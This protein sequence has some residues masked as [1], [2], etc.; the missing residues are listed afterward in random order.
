M[1]CA[2]NLGTVSPCSDQPEPEMRLQLVCWA[3]CPLYATSRGERTARVLRLF[4]YATFGPSVSPLLCFTTQRRGRTNMT[5]NGLLCRARLKQHSWKGCTCADCGGTREHEWDGCTCKRCRTSRAHDWDGC[6]C[7]RCGQQRDEGHAWNGCTCSRCSKTQ[8]QNHDW[9]GCQCQRCQKTQDDGHDW[10]GCTC[11]RCRS[12][13]AHD[14]NGCVCRTCSATRDEGHEWEGYA[15]RRCQKRDL[16]FVRIE[17]PQ[18]RGITAT[19]EIYAGP[20]RASALA[21]LKTRQVRKS[22]YY[23]EV[24]TPD[25]I[26]GLDV[27]EQYNLDRTAPVPQGIVPVRQIESLYILLE[28][29]KDWG[30]AHKWPVFEQYPQREQIRQI[31][32]SINAT[33]GFDGMRQVGYLFQVRNDD[34]RMLLEQFWHG[35]G[36]WLA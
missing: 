16:L 1:A 30:R 2:S 8:D 3:R 34:L 32:N 4:V 14:W 5:L 26:V 28:S 31:G 12:T 7:R 10:Q 24:S 29:A 19:K 27:Q 17:R 18:Q 9:Q 13:R 23:I 25:E 33:H 35:I 15:C 6:R 22:Y 36:E 21:Y 11:R 20:D